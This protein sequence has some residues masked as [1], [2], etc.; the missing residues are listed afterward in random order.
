MG[1]RANTISQHPQYGSA[2]IL[3]W[4]EFMGYWYFLEERYNDQNDYHSFKNEAE[5]NFELD[6]TVIVHEIQRLREKPD[7]KFDFDESFTNNQIADSL[8]ISLYE[9]PKDDEYV[10]WEW[11]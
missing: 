11:F 8:E 5:D 7:E 3:G 9:T 4:N 10:S 6:K 1:Y 2:F